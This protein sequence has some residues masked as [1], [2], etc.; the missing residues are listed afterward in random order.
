MKPARLIANVGKFQSE[1]IR[2]AFDY[3]TAVLNGSLISC[4][5][6]KQAVKRS[7]SLRKKYSYSEKDFRVIASIFYHIYIPVND[8]PTQF[9]P[10]AWQCW[11]LLN[12]FAIIDQ[13]TNKRLFTEA[14]LMVSRKSGK[15]FFGAAV[16][17]AYLTKYGG[18]LSQ[19][20]CA[21][22]TQQQAKQ[23][24]KYAKVIIRNSPALRSRI[25]T[26][27]DE[28]VFDDKSSEHTLTQLSEQQ[29]DRADGS[30]PSMCL[31]DEFHAY[32]N[33][34]MYQVIINGMGARAMPLS[35]IV[36]TAG[37]LTVG[38]PLF[39]KIQVGRKV[40]NGEVNDDHTFYAIYEQD[41]ETEATDENIDVLEKSNPGLNVTITRERLE[42]M[43]D[44]ALLLPSAWKHF[45]VKNC[46]LFRTSVDDPFI[47]DEMFVKCCKPIDFEALRGGR[48]WIGLDLSQAIDLTAFTVIVEHPETKELN[49]IPLHFFPNADNN[50]G[51]RVRANGVDLS[52]WIDE[53][54][55]I[56]H[57][58]RIDLDDVYNRIMEIYS[59]YDVQMSGY[60]PY[61][62]FDLIAK[63]KANLEISHIPIIPVS[64]SIT[65]M[66]PPAKYFEEL[67]ASK[68]VNLGQNPVLRY[69]NNNARI[70]FSRTS[71]LIRIAKDEDLN[72]IDSVIST[73]IALAVY[74]ET[75]FDALNH[76]ND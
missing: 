55:I 61:H 15:T 3:E 45:L 31:F 43:R 12:I 62:A 8:R 42:Q 69:C 10:S 47:A 53:G 74:M 7:Q 52:G 38:Y 27:R 66:S 17:L 14:L 33:E 28:L 13:K 9:L 72:P 16:L 20:F 56:A 23:A 25:K 67:V 73:V 26:Y 68:R 19:N 46:N 76:I 35:L 48:A 1:V 63:L 30:N 71:S 44:K 51:K 75:E 2:R 11:I 37:F 18:M 65:T 24:M 54:F 6:I 60:D 40:L 21:A 41:S 22:T 70:Q 49:V 36:T 39:E 59:F 34:K 5:T 64:Q 58:E 32:T 4:K 50:E 57:G 29:A